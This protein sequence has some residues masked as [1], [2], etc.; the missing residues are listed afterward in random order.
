MF[1]LFLYLTG[2]ILIWNIYRSGWLQTLKLVISVIVPSL[3]I[4]LFNIKA[5]RLIFRSP[6]IG[7]FSILP[8]SIFIY[9]GSRPLVSQILNWIDKNENDISKQDDVI[10]TEAFTV[11][12]EKNS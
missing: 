3:L 10:E 11:D 1:Y 6:I 2:L 4:V 5:G 9:R 7:I 8:T 12:D